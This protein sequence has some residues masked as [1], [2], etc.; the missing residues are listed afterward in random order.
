M[1]VIM[2]NGMTINMARIIVAIL[3]RFPDKYE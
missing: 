3:P 1:F 2:D